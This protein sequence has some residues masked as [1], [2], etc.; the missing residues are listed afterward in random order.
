MLG[1]LWGW[2]PRRGER[3]PDLRRARKLLAAVDAGGIPLNPARVNQIARSLGLE[4]SRNAAMEKTIGRIREA[5]AR[6][7]CRP[8]KDDGLR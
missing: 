8:S 7:S 3:C 4:V 2:W 1:W 6:G 5:V